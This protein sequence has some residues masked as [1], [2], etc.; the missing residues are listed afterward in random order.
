MVLVGDEGGVLGSAVDSDVALGGFD[1]LTEGVA[2][3]AFATGDTAFAHA[4][5]EAA[6]SIIGVA[7]SFDGEPVEEKLP[8]D[9]VGVALG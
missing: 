3:G 6:P 8:C 1:A 5:V 4:S 9:V 2:V 7:G